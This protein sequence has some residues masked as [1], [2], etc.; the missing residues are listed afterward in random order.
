V[1]GNPSPLDVTVG[2]NPVWVLRN[3]KII[4][5]TW[6]RPS[7]SSPIRLVDRRGHQINLAPGRTWVELLPRPNKPSHS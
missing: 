5:G 4:S 2:S 3:G 6:K 1:L 7:I